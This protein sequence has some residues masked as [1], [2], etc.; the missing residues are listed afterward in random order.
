MM[1]SSTAGSS[2][3][4]TLSSSVNPLPAS[5][6]SEDKRAGVAGVVQRHVINSTNAEILL[7]NFR[8]KHKAM[9]TTAAATWRLSPAAPGG[10]YH[11]GEGTE[12][13]VRS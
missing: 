4:F 9:S 12:V 5:V 2:A 8:Y 3:L 10:G 7:H 1:F 6:S 11:A 13:V